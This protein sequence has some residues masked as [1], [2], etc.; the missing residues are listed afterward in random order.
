[1]T[2]RLMGR[3]TAAAG[4]LA[5]I[6]L[7]GACSTAAD[8]VE[9][10]ATRTDPPLRVDDDRCV[11]P[12]TRG[13]A[14]AYGWFEMQ[15]PAATGYDD[16]DMPIYPGIVVVDVGQRLDRGS[17]AFRPAGT[18]RAGAAPLRVPAQSTAGS[19]ST[20][21]RGGLGTSVRGGSSGS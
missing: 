3:T 1:M 8:V 20:V 5:V 7:V 6:A 15:L 4:A 11:R 9:V 18:P 10:C 21:S 19:P 14:A 12:L 16:D 2:R 17:G 13:D